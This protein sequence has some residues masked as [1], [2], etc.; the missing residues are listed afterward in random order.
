MLGKIL[1]AA[2]DDDQFKSAV[3]IVR[4]L[5]LTGCRRSEGV[6]LKRT[7]IDIEGSRLRLDDS[8]EGASIRP[9][10]LPAV[11]LLDNQQR[12]PD[13][14]FV[15]PSTRRGKPLVGFPKYWRKLVK[16]TKLEGITPHILRHSFASVAND[17]GFTEATIAALM[18]HSKGTVTGRY[19]HAVD[20]AL[21]MAADTVAG[22]INGL[23]NGAQFKRMG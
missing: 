21:V 4:L 14:V 23:L 17:L 9:V 2:A 11:D 5:A 1:D 16:D 18:G 8:K 15:F 6:N 12:D 22:Y 7:E 3:S 19:I 20:T 10:G 13:D